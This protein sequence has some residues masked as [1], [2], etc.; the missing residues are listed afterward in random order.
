MS[1]KSVR[2]LIF[3]LVIL[4]VGIRA[5]LFFFKSFLSKFEILSSFKNFVDVIYGMNDLITYALIALI[6]ILIPFY[7]SKRSSEKKGEKN[8]LPDRNGPKR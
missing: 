3:T 1:A 4:L 6:I 2:N 7:L 5:A 8:A